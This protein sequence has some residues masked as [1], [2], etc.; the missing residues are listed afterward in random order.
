MLSPAIMYAAS[1]K[2][3]IGTIYRKLAIIADRETK[4]GRA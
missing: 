4:D 3:S 2:N 1:F